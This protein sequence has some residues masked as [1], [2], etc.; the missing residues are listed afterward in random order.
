MNIGTSRRP[1]EVII[2]FY[3]LFNLSVNKQALLFLFSI[4]KTVELSHLK[5][6]NKNKVLELSI[7]L[8]KHAWLLY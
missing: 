6:K 1:F 2:I 3:I 7:K 5:N 8:L 4:L